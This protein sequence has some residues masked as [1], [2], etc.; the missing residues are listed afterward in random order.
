MG[1]AQ[2]ALPSDEVTLAAGQ[3]TGRQ[4]PDSGLQKAGGRQATARTKVPVTMKRCERCPGG[5]VI[6][7]WGSPGCRGEGKGQEGTLV[8]SGRGPSC[9]G[10]WETGPVWVDLEVSERCEEAMPCS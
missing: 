1:R 6:R 4:E 7:A 9:V 2:S 8:S 5:S 10:C 3:R